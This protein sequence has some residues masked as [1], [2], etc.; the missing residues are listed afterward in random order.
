MKSILALVISIGISCC[1]GCYSKGS[2]TST[3]NTLEQEKSTSILGLID[4]N[5]VGIRELRY[6]S[7][8]HGLI[9]KKER[10][11]V[12]QLILDSVLIHEYFS[13]EVGTYPDSNYENR[14][15]NVHRIDD[16]IFLVITEYESPFG[17]LGRCGQ[18]AFIDINNYAVVNKTM[19]EGGKYHAPE[20]AWSDIDK[21]SKKEIVTRLVYPTSSVPLIDV[22]ETIYETQENT[23]ELVEALNTTT[24]AINCVDN[25]NG[26]PLIQRSY[27]F[28]TPLRVKTIEQYYSFNCSEDWKNIDS[29]KTLIDQKIFFLTRQNE[30]GVFN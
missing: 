25:T 16:N 9:N 13:E 21:D 24:E 6:I 15:L 10:G 28:E 22:F 5:L 20:I 27:Y 1:F 12:E 19:I 17:P 11:K 30:S 18:V 2:D 7:T 26:V 29:L 8:M 3:T 23:F 4:S 14:L